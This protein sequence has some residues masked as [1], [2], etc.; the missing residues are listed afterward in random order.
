M[1]MCVFSCEIFKVFFHV[2]E[3][4]LC[5]VVVVAV[6]V[7]FNIDTTQV[8]SGKVKVCNCCCMLELCCLLLLND[9]SVTM[10]D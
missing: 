9:P 7:S 10:T 5:Y 1:C 2:V 3:S 4:H 6:V 8:G